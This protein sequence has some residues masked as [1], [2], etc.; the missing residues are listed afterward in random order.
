MKKRLMTTLAT[1][2]LVGAMVVGGAASALA[3]EVNGKGDVTAAVT[4][5]NSPCAFSGL[6]DN[7]GGAVDP[8]VVQNW[9]HAKGAPVVIDAPRGASD[10]TLNFGGADLQDGCNARLHGLK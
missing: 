4:H 10:V 5:A 2:A 1:G 3:G 9:G 6:E 8:G 7:D